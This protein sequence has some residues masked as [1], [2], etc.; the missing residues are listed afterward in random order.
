VRFVIITAWPTTGEDWPLAESAAADERLQLRLRTQGRNPIRITGYSPVTGHAEPGWVAELAPDEG[1]A[2]GRE[3]RQ[4][5]IYAVN[6]DALQVLCCADGQ[7][8][9]VGGF[10][11]RVDAGPPR[12]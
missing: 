6:G 7:T 3:F 1:L 10:R 8:A 2:I 5:A 4:H 11:E 9:A 12:P